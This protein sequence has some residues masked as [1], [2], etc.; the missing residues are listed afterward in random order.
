ML[1]GGLLYPEHESMYRPETW[2]QPAS[3]TQ[4]TRVPPAHAHHSLFSLVVGILRQ[5]VPDQTSTADNLRRARALRLFGCSQSSF[6][7]SRLEDM[8][9][10]IGRSIAA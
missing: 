2:T 7:L 9:R 8:V 3:E 1:Y 10:R 6:G 5:I 4:G